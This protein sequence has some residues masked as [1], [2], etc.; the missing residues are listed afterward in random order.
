M[1]RFILLWILIAMSACVGSSYSGEVSKAEELI[2]QATNMWGDIISSDD[3]AKIIKTCDVK[4]EVD[5]KAMEHLE[6]ATQLAKSDEE[7]LYAQYLLN[8]VESSA[9]AT[10]KYREYAE[11]MLNGDESRANI[12]A[13]EANSYL[14]E[15]IAWKKRAAQ[16]KPQ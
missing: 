5:A 12:A 16:L 3:Y 4:A 8:Y 11:L 1:N 15:V 2:S 10:Q 9:K 14:E 13:L 6:K 7:R